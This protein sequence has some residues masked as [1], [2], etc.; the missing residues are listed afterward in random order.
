MDLGLVLTDPFSDTDE[1]AIQ[2]VAD[3]VKT[4][5]SALHERLSVFWGTPST[6]QGRVPGGRFPLLDRLDLIENGRLLE[7]EDARQ[8]R[9]RPTQ[10]ELLVAGASRT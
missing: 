3:N 5:G 4:G 2:S 9:V 1:D 7:G 6:L 10:T 8:R